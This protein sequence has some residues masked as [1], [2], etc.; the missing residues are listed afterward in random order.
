V[1]RALAIVLLAAATLAAQ[2]RAREDPSALAASL[3]A[4]TQALAAGRLDE[5]D[6]HLARAA[7]LG[8]DIR[9]EILRGEV[10]L[11]RKDAAGAESAIGDAIR[12]LQPTGEL[13]RVANRTHA[14]AL[15]E[16]GR[17]RDAAPAV[18]RSLGLD[19]AAASSLAIAA[20]GLA[21]GG[22]RTAARSV[23]GLAAHLAP[24]R[25][26]LLATSIALAL[27]EGDSGGALRD[28]ES[29]VGRAPGDR[30]AR[31]LRARALHA[32]GKTAEARD[33]LAVL[34]RA[35]GLDPALLRVLAE[36]DLASGLVAEAEAAF[37]RAGPV[38]VDETAKLARAWLDQGDPRRAL[39]R[40]DGL[41]DRGDAPALGRIRAQAHL[42]RLD[43]P[44][45]RAA[46]DRL[47]EPT[48]E[49]RIARARAERLADDL[50]AA[51]KIL[52]ALLA[53]DAGRHAAR[54]E[55][56][57]VRLLEG[58]V[59]AARRLLDEGF[60]LAPDHAP[61]ARALEDLV[62]ELAPARPVAVTAVLGAR[63]LSLDG[64]TV[65]DGTAEALA[66]LRAARLAAGQ[67]TPVVRLL[68]EGRVEAAA[69]QRAFDVLTAA[70]F[71]RISI[72]GR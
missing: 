59:P 45:A 61:F 53:E 22:E 2:D 35:G 52:E 13:A 17:F 34:D 67:G 10:L 27:E 8:R 16:L 56:V 66:Q 30:D 65:A 5:A 33:A 26:D 69:V 42:D 15:V 23:L 58:A 38:G 70:G 3:S 46:L 41:G 12:T 43:G 44:A 72:E 54:V 37:G 18:L 49:D 20:R 25:T 14:R 48:V 31:V 63:S 24:E 7:A 55:L 9:T 50:G 64:V 19:A 36:L 28:A 21:E 6:Q 47:A 71:S 57:E 40:L 68:L 51:A 60:A 39:Q 29:L 62:P 32:A 11:A 4:A 1:T